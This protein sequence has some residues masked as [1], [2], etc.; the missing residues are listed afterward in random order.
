ME[1]FENAECIQRTIIAKSR[2]SE[3]TC[4]RMLREELLELL[5]HCKCRARSRRRR[6]RIA[7][8][9]SDAYDSEP[10]PPCYCMLLLTILDANAE[11]GS[12]ILRYWMYGPHR[13]KH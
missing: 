11:V 4:V 8:S 12:P 1:S 6:A 13:A 3:M 9:C 7:L 5:L 2:S 10:V